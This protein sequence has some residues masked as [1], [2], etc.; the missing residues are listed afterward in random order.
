M[1]VAKFSRGC[2]MAI[3]LIPLLIGIGGP[4]AALIGELFSDTE[5]PEKFKQ[6]LQLLD[7]RLA[8]MQKQLCT[9]ERELADAKITERLHL[10]QIL[11][12]RGQVEAKR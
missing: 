12:L 1:A 11:W 5:P 8:E 6:L 2:S 4:A 7:E 9:C 3:P 10:E